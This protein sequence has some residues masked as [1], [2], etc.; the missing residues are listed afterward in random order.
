MGLP[1]ERE[2][3]RFSPYFPL[4]PLETRGNR[5][6]GGRGWGVTVGYSV[7]GKGSKSSSNYDELQGGYACSRTVFEVSARRKKPV[8]GEFWP[9]SSSST[10]PTPGCLPNREPGG[11]LHS[12]GKI[13][14][15]Y[16]PFIFSFSCGMLLSSK[17]TSAVGGAVLQ[18]DVLPLIVIQGRDGKK[19]PQPVHRSRHLSSTHAKFQ[20]SGGGVR[21]PAF[22]PRV[23]CFNYIVLRW[24]GHILRL[25]FWI[26]LERRD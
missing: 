25:L 10:P 12:H 20:R 11:G 2:N 17:K 6:R 13:P 8:Q 7:G 14:S 1:T 24:F 15:G 23:F 16:F 18:E 9:L 4:G 26:D 19:P 3:P 5:G 22:P 21:I